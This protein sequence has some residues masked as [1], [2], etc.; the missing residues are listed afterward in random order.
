M[1][2]LYQRS[3]AN[4]KQPLL[5]VSEVAPSF[6]PPPSS[7]FTFGAESS[8]TA[9]GFGPPTQDPL[10]AFLPS[11]PQVR[12]APQSVQLP[13][14]SEMLQV[15]PPSVVPPAYPQTFGQVESETEGFSRP[16]RGIS[17]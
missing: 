2:V 4:Q 13:Q 15:P 1:T 11:A 7:A 12:F 8:N 6:V 17:K 9:A 5:P 3:V 14:G 16:P 10:Q